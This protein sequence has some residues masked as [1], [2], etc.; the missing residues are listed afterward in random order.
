MRLAG[1]HAFVTGGRQGIG[2]G[3]VDAFTAEGATVVTCG[4]GARPADLPDAVGWSALD[5]SDPASVNAIAGTMQGPDI[6]VN[7]AGV[8][9]KR[10]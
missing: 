1:K 3:I 5:V 4:R 9:A 7:N 6:L 8:Q 10:P 2:R